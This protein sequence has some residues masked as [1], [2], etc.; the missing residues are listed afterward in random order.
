ML[1]SLE[2][3]QRRPRAPALP[4]A[5]NPSQ[6]SYRL[7]SQEELKELSLPP[8]SWLSPGSLALFIE[9]RS[10]RHT[11]LEAS[12]SKHPGILWAGPWESH[13]GCLTR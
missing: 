3:P 4:A 5:N 8:R 6:S 10:T 13:Q 1:T 9:S 2:F 7:S 12:P 11:A